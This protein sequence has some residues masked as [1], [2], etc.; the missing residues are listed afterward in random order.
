MKKGWNRNRAGIR[1]LVAC[2]LLAVL[3]AGCGKQALACPYDELGWETDEKALAAAKGECKDTYAST[4]GGETYPY[5]GSYLG[6]EGTVKY[7]YDEKGQLACVAFAYGSEDA[8][9]IEAF[10]KELTEKTE[11]A[12]GK[13]DYEPKEATN[14]GKKW[15]LENGRIIISVMM[16]DTNKALQI[17]Y[18]HPDSSK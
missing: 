4:Y 5:A 2:L 8:S 13:P 12:Y 17:A 3:P 18:I 9:E 6:R 11:A 14:Y 7:M 10:Y 15:E 16:T 1:L